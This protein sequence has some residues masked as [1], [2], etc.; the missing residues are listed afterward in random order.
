MQ[1]EM[2]HNG[3][4]QLKIRI[5]S[6]KVEQHL[7]IVVAIVDHGRVSKRQNKI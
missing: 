4:S 2:T 6:G 7:E 1:G 3:R 5:F